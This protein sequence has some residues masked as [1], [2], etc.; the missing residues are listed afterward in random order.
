[1]WLVNQLDA[2]GTYLCSELGCKQF[3]AQDA[4][5][6]RETIEVAEADDV[7]LLTLPIPVRAAFEIDLAGSVED[8]LFDPFEEFGGKLEAL[9]VLLR[10]RHDLVPIVVGGVLPEVTIES[11]GFQRICEG[12]RRKLGRL[13]VHEFFDNSQLE[14]EVHEPSH[15]AKLAPDYDSVVM[16]VPPAP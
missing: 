12:P 5:E 15:T 6:I 9:E 11:L 13:P 3:R 4:L 7:E 1:M 16:M 2:P 10:L 14:I 8:E